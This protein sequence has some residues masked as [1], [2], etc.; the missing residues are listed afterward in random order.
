LLIAFLLASLVLPIGAQPPVVK[1]TETKKET[2][3]ETKT[4]PATPAMPKE[5]VD[6]LKQVNLKTDAASLLDYLRKQT[7]P[8]ADPKQ[9]D[10]LI[11]DLGD[12]VFQVRE[13][14]FAKIIT[15]GKTAIVGVKD[16]SE[17]Q[18]SEKDFDPE[19]KHRAGDLRRMLEAKVEPA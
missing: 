9:M 8:E 19:I 13:A 7:H 4:T 5:D 10:A 1:T 16:A 2:K 18:P 17:K 6:V 12:D 15:L 3:T 11:R 14:A